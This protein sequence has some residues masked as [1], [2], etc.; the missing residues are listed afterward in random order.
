MVKRAAQREEMETSHLQLQG[1]NHTVILMMFTQKKSLKSS[2]VFL[3]T[4]KANQTD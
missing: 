3:E 1:M 4:R 2:K